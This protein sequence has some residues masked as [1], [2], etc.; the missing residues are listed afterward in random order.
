MMPRRVYV[1]PHTYSLAIDRDGRLDELE[2]LN[3]L[4]DFDRQ[5]I[6]VKTPQTPGM[7]RD[8]VLHEVLHAVF[9]QLDVKRRMKEE[10]G[11]EFEEDV[12]YALAP[13][14]LAVLKDNPG[15]VKYLLA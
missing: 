15:L 13:R 12:V 9:D 8:T 7:E 3:G 11:K 14:L 10:V 2:D 5:R 1:H 6:W 4:C